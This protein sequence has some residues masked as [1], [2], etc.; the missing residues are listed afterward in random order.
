MVVSLALV[1]LLSAAGAAPTFA[2]DYYTGMQTSLVIDQGGYET[3][4]QA[5]CAAGTTGCKIQT[6]NAGADVYSQGS[7]NRTR[8]DS[9]G[10][11]V[12]WWEPQRMDMQIVP[13]NKSSAHKYECAEY[14]SLAGEWYSWAR[15]GDGIGPVVP[16]GRANVTQIGA[17][18]N[19]TKN[20]AVYKWT[21][22]AL[23]I[24]FKKHTS[25]VDDSTTPPKPFFDTQIIEPF[26]KPT[27]A[28]G[29]V[30]YLG[31][32]TGAD[33]DQYFDID[34][35]SLKSCRLSTRCGQT[36]DLHSSPHEDGTL[37]HAARPA[38]SMLSVARAQRAA[39]APA[40]NAHEQ[41][42]L[43]PPTFAKDYTSKFVSDVFL[44]QGGAKAKASGDV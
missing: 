25:Y 13:A 30:S 6:S 14:C 26:G 24:P 8:V 3:F 34:P 22:H 40:D 20:C 35:A 16:A 38:A 7:K 18:G 39:L 28:V 9:N 27:G 37:L 33:V 10:M 23:I 29:N 5:C 12:M 42:S 44:S 17:P 41:P 43:T 31:F 15:I 2:D 19:T 21:E 36:A 1:P 32:K 4:G 11:R